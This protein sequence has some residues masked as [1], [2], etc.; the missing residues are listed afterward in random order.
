MGAQ[1]IAIGFFAKAFSYAERFDRNPISLKRMLRHVTLEHGLA[2]GG[3]FFLAG[4][5]GCLWVTFG[6]AASGFGP[7][8]AGL[9]AVLFWSMWMFLGVQTIFSSFFL[10]MLGISRGTYIGDYER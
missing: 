3:I 8:Y 4:F 7:L 5:A 6:W 9:R 1:L 10:S 2:V